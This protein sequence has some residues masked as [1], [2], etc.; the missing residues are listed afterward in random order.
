ML[1][2]R[3]TLNNDEADDG[4]RMGGKK[5]RVHF[6]SRVGAWH[7]VC[8][9]VFCNANGGDTCAQKRNAEFQR[10]QC[11]AGGAS[12]GVGCPEGFFAMISSFLHGFASKY[13]Q[14]VGFSSLHVFCSDNV[15]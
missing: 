5:E 3:R 12:A 15:F 14:N 7:T 2:S 4:V 11:E 1:A 6:C 13:A 10:L 8:V 9:C